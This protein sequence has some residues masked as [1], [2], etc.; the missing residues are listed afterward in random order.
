[1]RNDKIDVSN[2]TQL[3]VVAGGTVV[4]DFELKFRVAFVIILGPGLSQKIG[5]AH[6]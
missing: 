1:M 3:V 4:N 5:R 6:V 2:R